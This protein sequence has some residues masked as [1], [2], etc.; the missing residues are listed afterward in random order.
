MLIV[1][2]PEIIARGIC[3]SQKCFL[4]IFVIFLSIFNSKTY[5]L[6]LNLYIV[7]CLSL[8]YFLLLHFYVLYV[9]CFF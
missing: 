1:F 4:L 7:L 6:L 2:V 8:N 9:T 3:A 5:F